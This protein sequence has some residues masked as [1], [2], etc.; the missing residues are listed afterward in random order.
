M[1]KTVI[2]NNVTYPSIHECSN[3]YNVK[4][5][6]MQAWMSGRNKMPQKYIDLG[7]RYVTQEEI[8]QIKK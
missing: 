6:T 7:L 8:D 4:R 1:G 2:C 5:V 3:Y